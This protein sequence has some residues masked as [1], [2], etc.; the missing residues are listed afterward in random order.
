MLLNRSPYEFHRNSQPCC[1]V[2]G[3]LASDDQID[4]SS[5]TNSPTIM[6]TRPLSLVIAGGG[7]GGH[8]FPGIAVAEQVLGSHDDS[9]V[10]FIGTGNPFETRVLN[11][12]KFKPRGE[13]GVLNPRDVVNGHTGCL[14]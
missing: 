12:L 8:L 13:C 7:T 14:R 3:T 6:T 4:S 2:F 1:L 9:Q 5:Q 11:V 10:H